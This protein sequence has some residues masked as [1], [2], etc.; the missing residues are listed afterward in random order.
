MMKI[1][2]IKPLSIAA[3]FALGAPALAQDSGTAAPEDTVETQAPEAEMPAVDMGTEVTGEERKPGQ[4]YVTEVVG[5]WE[6]K[7]LTNPNGD[8]PCQMYQL[9]KDEQGN[10]VAEVSLG[11]LPEGGQAVSGGN[12]CGAA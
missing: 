10:S 6:M 1:D 11:K 4:P 12:H 3:L 5:D 7:C 9:L 2:M 8:D